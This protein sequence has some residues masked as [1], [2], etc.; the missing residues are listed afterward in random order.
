LSFFFIISLLFL[1]KQFPFFPSK[2]LKFGI[3]FL[4]LCR[5]CVSAGVSAWPLVSI[6][7]SNC[8][9]FWHFSFFL[10]F[11][12]HINCKKR[13]TKQIVTGGKPT[14]KNKMVKSFTCFVS[15]LLF[16]FLHEKKIQYGGRGVVLQTQRVS[17]SFKNPILSNQFYSNKIDI[18][19]E[20]TKIKFWGN[21]KEKNFV[22]RLSS[23]FFFHVLFFFFWKIMKF[24]D[25]LFF[26]DGSETGQTRPKSIQYPEDGRREVVKCI[27]MLFF[28]LLMFQNKIE[29]P[30][31]E[32]MFKKSG[33][34]Q[35]EFR[36]NVDQIEW[37]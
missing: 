14:A 23:D 6:W 33:T 11:L 17:S 15:F 26:E 24:F 28:L 16:G 4:R 37:N 10:T 13:I 22:K 7:A 35:I 9:F 19:L 32:I 20:E 1:S 3:E 27:I 8:L 30:R 29:F 36:E 12:Y 31:V 2:I 25:V 18:F 5:Q 21:K 34:F